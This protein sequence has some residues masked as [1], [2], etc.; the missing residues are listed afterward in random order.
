MF[1]KMKREASALEFPCAFPIKAFGRMKSGF[2]AQALRIVRRHAP[3]FDA[4]SMRSRASRHGNYLAVTFTVQATSREQ[5]DAI[6]R[7]LSACGDLIM[8]L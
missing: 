3:D 7:E 2:E 1:T 4:A 8:V 6:Y 5:L